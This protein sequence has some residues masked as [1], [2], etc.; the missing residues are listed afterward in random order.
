MLTMHHHPLG[1][2]WSWVSELEHKQHHDAIIYYL[3]AAI[4][5]HQSNYGDLEPRT[6]IARPMALVSASGIP[7]LRRLVSARC[8]LYSD[9]SIQDFTRYSLSPRPEKRSEDHHNHSL[10]ASILQL[11]YGLSEK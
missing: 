2:A 8:S 6:Y 9:A 5:E 1:V 11:N 3:A 4:N 7:L 10:L